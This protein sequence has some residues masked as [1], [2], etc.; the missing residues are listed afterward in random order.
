M[1]EWNYENEQW[2]KLPIHLRHLP[3]FT[4]HLDWASVFIRWL[5][6]MF[7]K[8]IFFK[9]YIRLKVVGDFGAVYKSHPRAIV[10][11]NH[12]S[13]LDAI[14]IAAAIPFRYWLSLYFAA[15]KDYF[16]NNYWMTFF[17][18]HCIGAIPIDRKD[19]K[20]QAVRLCVDLLNKLNSIWLVMF[21]EGTRS[22]TG[23]ISTFKKGVSTFSIRTQT[24][25]LFLFLEG[26]YDLW[27][28]GAGF[29]KMGKLIVHVG[30][31]QMPADIDTIYT[32]YKNWVNS[33]QP[34]LFEDEKSD[35]TQDDL[36]QE[37]LASSD[38]AEKEEAEKLSSEP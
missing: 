8:Y 26:A 10:I 35:L 14:S 34:G 12:S 19:K 20:G 9:F 25:I 24:P 11:S 21:P 17:S 27:P 4:R 15:A 23:K 32:N 7:L 16:F 33:I 28:K 13:H 18:K 2:T 3:L 29:A 38:Q 1:K 36:F 37:G 30:P 6:A 31:V 5:W 22:K